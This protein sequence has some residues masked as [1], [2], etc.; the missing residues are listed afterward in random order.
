[1]PRPSLRR[2]TNPLIWCAAIFCALLSVAVIVTGIVI[3]VGYIVIRPKVPQ[4]IVT[5]AQLDRLDFDQAGILTVKTTIFIKAENDNP[6]AHATFYATK[7]LLGFHGVRVAQLR[8]D[9]PVEVGKNSSVDLM[10]EV[11]STP[12]P[13]DPEEQNSVF[14]SLSQNLIVFDLKGTT[15]TRWRVGLLGSVKF[16]LHLDCHLQFPKIGDVIYPKCSTKSR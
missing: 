14:L 6:K 7:F 13:L 10:F 9:F 1:M 2:P 3:I 5:S 15:R 8:A 12:I 11:E 16:W 4:M